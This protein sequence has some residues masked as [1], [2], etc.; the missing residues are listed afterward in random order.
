[1]LVAVVLTALAVV[2]GIRAWLTDDPLDAVAVG[3]ALLAGAV[4]AIHHREA[5]VLDRRARADASDLA[6]ILA[7]FARAASPDEVADALLRDLGSGTGA[8]HVIVARRRGPEGVVDATLLSMHPDVPLTNASLA[9]WGPAAARDP[10]AAADHVERQARRAFGLKH[11]LAV[12]LV[13]DDDVLGA[14]VVSRRRAG[15]WPDAARR[16]LEDAAAE[17]AAALTR[18]ASHRA[19]EERATTDPLTGLPNRRYFEEYVDLVRRGRRADDAMG[20]LMVDVDHFKQCND[21]YGHA[22]G[23]IVLREI[24]QVISGAVRDV[25]VP[26][27]FGGEEFVV[28][29]RNPDPTVALEVGERIRTAVA[30]LDL[31]AH[32]MP[33]VTVSVGV[34]LTRRG[35]ETVAD[36]IERADH[37]LYRAKRFGRNRVEAA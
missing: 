13:A 4:V 5:L 21:H 6:R 24:A 31:S 8:D 12:P 20:V 26:A 37:A 14:I 18:A 17:A 36:L 32:G 30:A 16:M 22:M 27:R 11:T 23:D 9:A 15:V 35:G 10:Y 3:M 2:G 28:L 33:G 1:M 34:G 29:L 7:G 25:D 19:A